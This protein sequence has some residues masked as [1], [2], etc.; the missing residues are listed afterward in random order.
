MGLGVA[1]IIIVAVISSVDYV[2]DLCKHHIMS[3]YKNALWT[4]HATG[5]NTAVFLN[6]SMID[7]WGQV[8]ISLGDLTYVL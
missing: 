6:L 7:I 8:I 5:F 2:L 1:V 3:I 4:I